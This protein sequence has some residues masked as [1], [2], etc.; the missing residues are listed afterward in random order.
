MGTCQYCGNERR[1][2][3]AHIV[4]AAFCREMLAPGETTLYV[5]AMD[6]EQRPKRLPVGPYDQRILCRD[7]EDRFEKL[8]DYAARL[9]IRG[10]ETA[11]RK[12][13]LEQSEIYVCEQF[14]YARLKLF[15]L[16]VLWRASVSTLSF[17]NRV[18]LGSRLARVGEM[19]DR[20]DPGVPEELGFILTRWVAVPGKNLP[21]KFLASPVKREYD[22]AQ[23]VKLYL[24]YFVAEVCISPGGFREP[25]S[26]LVVAPDRPITAI[27]L[28]LSGSS[29]VGVFHQTLLKQWRP[30]GGKRK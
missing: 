23:C 2:V 20:S 7:C 22:G 11:F 3:D 24:A 19:L 21:P 15:V 4:P 26:D 9:L 25:F 12:E 28:P 14:D 6:P 27:G 29:D 13:M 17:Y 16:S 8:D 1:L 30:G 10:R 5:M 18:A